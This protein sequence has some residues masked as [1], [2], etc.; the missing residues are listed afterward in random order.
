MRIGL[1]VL[2]LG[3]VLLAACAGGS[4]RSAG[5]SFLNPVCAPDGSV[6]YRQYANSGG[7]YDGVKASVENCSWNK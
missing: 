3:S 2:A 7:M 6:V 4:S 1:V 5:G